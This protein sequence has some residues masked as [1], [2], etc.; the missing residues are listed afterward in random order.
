MAIL[1]YRKLLRWTLNI[2]FFV[3]T[4]FYHKICGTI[5][6]LSLWTRAYKGVWYH[7]LSKY[8]SKIEWNRWF[9]RRNEKNSNNAIQKNLTLLICDTL[10]SAH[11]HP[12]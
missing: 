8:V 3:N 4:F 1:F 11:A 5:L 7:S 12:Y 9:P 2:S 6:L 10:N